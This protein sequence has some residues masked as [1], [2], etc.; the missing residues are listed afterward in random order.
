MG[1]ARCLVS[2]FVFGQVPIHKN[3]VRK[4]VYIY[5]VFYIL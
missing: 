5:N 1:V 2:I 4:H 3:H